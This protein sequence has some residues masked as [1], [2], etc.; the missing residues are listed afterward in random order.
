MLHCSKASRA[1]GEGEGCSVVRDGAALVGRVCGD[2]RAGPSSATSPMMGIHSASAVIRC[3][4]LCISI[5]YFPR[6]RA[7]AVAVT[8]PLP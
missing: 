8:L 1:G 5:A 4:L 6:L 3:T 2:W 7:S